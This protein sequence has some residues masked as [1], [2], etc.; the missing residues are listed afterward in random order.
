MNAI[1]QK[2]LSDIEAGLNSFNQTKHYETIEMVVDWLEP[3]PPAP[4]IDLVVERRE[5][6]KAWL[7]TL[8]TIDK[9]I[10]PAFNPDALPDTNVMP[11]K[12]G[13]VQFP[14]GVS[15]DFIK[16]PAK[17]AEYVKAL[18]QNVQ[19]ANEYRLQLKL[20]RLEP[21]ASQSAKRYI[22]TSYERTQVDQA[23]LRKL[24]AD[25]QLAPPRKTWVDGLLSKV[26]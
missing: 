26:A 18:Q 24:A 15:P 16:D 10:D 11:P 23:E 7:L 22:T 9:A 20:R 13:D 8:S 21:R 14:P 19:K 17:K 25:T 4:G 5:V 12:V 1:T 6:C 3:L 2:A